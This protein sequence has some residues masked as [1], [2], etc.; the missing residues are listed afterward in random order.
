MKILLNL[1][2]NIEKLPGNLTKKDV[3]VPDE[4]RIKR[5]VAFIIILKILEYCI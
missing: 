4:E 3:K 1:P 5:Y 2:K